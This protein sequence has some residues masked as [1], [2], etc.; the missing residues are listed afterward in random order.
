MEESKDDKND[1]KESEDEKGGTVVKIQDEKTIEKNDD[2]DI[3]NN[4][5]DRNS[6]FKTE[7]KIKLNKNFI[8]Q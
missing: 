4:T 2:S 7:G 6:E 5:V 3:N 1:T 8:N